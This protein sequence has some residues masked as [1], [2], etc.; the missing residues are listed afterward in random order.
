VSVESQSHDL[1]LALE[2]QV[3][4]LKAELAPKDRIIQDQRE[5]LASKDQIIQQQVE[6]IHMLSQ[7]LQNRALHP[8]ARTSVEDQEPYV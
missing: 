4:V 6:T 8:H 2:A 1:I 5:K 7:A 3:V